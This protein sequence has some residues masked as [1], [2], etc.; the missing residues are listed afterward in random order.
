MA[1]G[2]VVVSAVGFQKSVGSAVPPNSTT[3]PLAN[4]VPVTVTFVLALPK[5]IVAGEIEEIAGCG[6][7]IVTDADADCAE[8]STLTA[9]TVTVL[10]EGRIV[11]AV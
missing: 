11:G 8:L 9:V 1:A 5:A 10:G 7:T 3:D 2:I 4:P 6:F